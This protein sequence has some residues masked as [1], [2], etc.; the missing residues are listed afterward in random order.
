MGLPDVH[1]NRSMR[2][3]KADGMISFD[4]V[5]SPKRNPA[6][7]EARASWFQ[8]YAGFSVGFVEDTIAQLRL[9]AGA[10]LMDPWL[11]A[12]TTSQ[13][14]SANGFRVK[15]YDLNPA[16]L[17]V[18]KA[19]TLASSAVDQ[20]PN[21]LELISQR[22]KRNV[23]SNRKFPL[24][25]NEPL[26]Q[27]LQPGSARVFR[28][29]ERSVEAV[30]S[31]QKSFSADTIWNRVGQ[32]SATVAFFYLG[33]FRTFRHFIS[34][35]Q[36]SNPTWVK[37]SEGKERVY[38]SPDRILNRLLKEIDCL[39]KTLRSETRAM[40]LV[41]DRRCVI[42]QASSLRL[43]IASESVDAVIS[44]PPYCTRI[45]YV[46]ATLPELAVI[47][48]PNGDSV[49]RLREKMI[50]TPTIDKAQ[51]DG[52]SAWGRTCSQ[53]LSSVQHHPS[54]A[55]ST[56]YLKYYRQ[57]FASAFASLKE[58]N[59]VLKK[60]GQCVLVVQDSYY[61]EMQNDLPRIFTEMAKGLGWNVKQRI[62]FHVKRTLAG[63]N[64]EVRQ[65]RNTCHAT[66]SALVFLK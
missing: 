60:S 17:L 57:Y 10:T 7:E 11:G 3:A 25:T 53:F 52:N 65:Y 44:S 62:D 15:G 42:K 13:V 59:R 4:T 12:G 19:R 8:Y 63:V 35:F 18:A 48:Y 29:L 33:L 2:P 31:K 41:S 46:R 38:L 28:I 43:P 36:G 23:K 24:L 16:V 47:S 66:E 55:S 34:D 49:R 27:W 51:K 5:R 54:K 6:T 39:S 30:F 14:A 9:R 58:I 40:P 61:K 45:D 32:T 26:E 37:V 20:I 22:F 56:Y 64:P 1:V 21:L 50:G